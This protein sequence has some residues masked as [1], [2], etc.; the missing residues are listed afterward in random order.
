MFGTEDGT[1]SS[2]P[3]YNGYSYITANGIGA[4]GSRT[5]QDSEVVQQIYD[6]LFAVVT[7]SQG[8]REL[9]TPEEM[10]AAERT[11]W[12]EDGTPACKTITNA[13]GIRFRKSPMM[14]KGT[15]LPSPAMGSMRMEKS[16]CW[17]IISM[18]NKVKFS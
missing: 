11:A 16:T 9:F 1:V 3:A 8:V 2:V 7:D 17:N 15:L 5:G 18:M 6:L 14:M 4:Y 10:E 13:A 12:Y